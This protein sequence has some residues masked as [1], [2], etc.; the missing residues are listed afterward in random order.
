[1]QH[2]INKFEEFR[3]IF[4]FTLS[5]YA[6]TF[7]KESRVIISTIQELKNSFHKVFD[8]WGQLQKQKKKKTKKTKQ[9]SG[10]PYTESDRKV[11]LLLCMAVL[12]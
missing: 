5:V 11:C 7:Y 8:C 2:N 9:L 6:G 12:D 1:M 10:I 3:N 4:T